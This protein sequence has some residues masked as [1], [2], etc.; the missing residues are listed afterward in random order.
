MVSPWV[1]RLT[2]PPPSSDVTVN[3]QREKTKE[4]KQQQAYKNDSFNKSI[5]EHLQSILKIY[6]SIMNSFVLHMH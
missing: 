2:P 5:I 6:S 3:A 4:I 1:V